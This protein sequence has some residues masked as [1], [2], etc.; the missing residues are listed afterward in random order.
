M[1]IKV[2]SKCKRELLADVNHFHKDKSCLFGLKS[3]CKECCGYK[4]TNNVL[5]KE[6]YKICSKCKRE[7]PETSEYYYRKSSISSG[8]ISRCK[9]CEG[10][11]FGTYKKQSVRFIDPVNNQIMRICTECNN[12]FPETDIYFR[13]IKTGNKYYSKCIKC[14]MQIQNMY[15]RTE[16][17]K[18]YRRH[19]RKINKGQESLYNSMYQKNNR[20][21]INFLDQKRRALKRQLPAT[22]TNQDWEE[23]LKYFDYKDAYTGLPMEIIS[24]DH[25]IPLSKRGGYVKQNIV[26]CEKNINASKCNRDM[27]EWYK[28]QEFFSE[29]RLQ[30]IYDWIGMKDNIQQLSIL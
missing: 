1:D 19:Y 26:P 4:F 29:Q 11:K 7:L 30:K 18:A 28:K 3:I 9:E 25:V 21:R 14:A 15:H 17:F 10:G 6:G 27:E 23:C 5:A 8:L 13:K 24:Q 16:E 12:A 22:L 2:C 20:V